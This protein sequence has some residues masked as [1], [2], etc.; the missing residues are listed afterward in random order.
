[1]KTKPKEITMKQWR[2]ELAEKLGV[3]NASIYAMMRR[4]EIPWPK[5]RVVNQRVKFVILQ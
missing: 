3:H 4:G 5:M 1:M 2:L